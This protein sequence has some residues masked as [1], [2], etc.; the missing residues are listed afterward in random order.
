MNVARNL[1]N[2]RLKYHSE[3]I[4][5]P[6]IYVN[7]SVQCSNSTKFEGSNFKNGFGNDQNAKISNWVSKRIFDVL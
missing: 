7:K 6:G 2:N 4:V 3:T 1:S 5:K